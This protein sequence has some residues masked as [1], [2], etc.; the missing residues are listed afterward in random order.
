MLSAEEL[1]LLNCGA[2]EDLAMVLVVS[3]EEYIFIPE[4][5]TYKVLD[6]LRTNFKIWE[7]ENFALNAIYVSQWI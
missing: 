7:I 6:T 4:F 5:E 3:A 2:G 1:M